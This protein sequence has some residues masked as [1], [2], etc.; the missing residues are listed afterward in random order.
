MPRITSSDVS[1]FR[2]SLESPGYVANHVPVPHW[3]P[4][5]QASLMAPG[6]EEDRA[7]QRMYLEEV[8]AEN[9][10]RQKEAEKA[11]EEEQEGGDQQSAGSSSSA[12]GKKQDSNGDSAQD[13]G[14]SRPSPARAAG[15][16]SGKARP[17]KA[18]LSSSA[19]STDGSTRE[20]GPS[21]QSPSDSSERQTKQ[22]GPTQGLSEETPDKGGALARGSEQ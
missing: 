3:P 4:K 14:Q 2:E 18:A 9:E 16:R 19:S 10:R 15:N 8:D 12:S 21:Q 5:H 13:T 17:T 20:T 11:S 22:D 6:N 1:N 7:A